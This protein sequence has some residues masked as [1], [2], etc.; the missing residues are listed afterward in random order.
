[1]TQ[2]PNDTY[3]R[4]MPHQVEFNGGHELSG[5][6]RNGISYDDERL[7]DIMVDPERHSDLYLELVEETP[8][9]KQKPWEPGLQEVAEQGM[10]DL[11][12]AE[13]VTSV[14]LGDTMVDMRKGI[15]I[16]NAEPKAKAEFARLGRAMHY[17]NISSDPKGLT[18]TGDWLHFGTNRNYAGAPDLLPS[19]MRVYVS[20]RSEYA[21]YVTAAV[22]RDSMKTG[23]KPNGKVFDDSSNTKGISARADKI[24]FVV[25]TQ[26]QLD[27]VLGSLR[28][29][30]AQA[31]HMFTDRAPLLAEK[32]DITGVSL[33]EEPLREGD[34]LQ[35]SFTSSR[36]RVLDEAWDQVIDQLMGKRTAQGEVATIGSRVFDKRVVDLQTAVGNGSIQRENVLARFRNAVASIAPTKGISTDNFALNLAL[37]S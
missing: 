15:W 13:F 18:E 12:K 27:T 32:T 1:M 30:Q 9:S 24:L 21:G 35:E 7:L 20:P 11:V 10:L 31:P 14:P 8:K 3:P 17:Q 29:T 16:L 36:E 34:N 22:I 6:E 28:D 37:A 5:I 19:Q 4:P 23:Y 26:S 25:S 2:P 33:G